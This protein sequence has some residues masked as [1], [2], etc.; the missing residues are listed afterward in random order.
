MVLMLNQLATLYRMRQSPVTESESGTSIN[1]FRSAAS[2]T[3]SSTTGCIITDFLRILIGW[4]F[5]RFFADFVS[6]FTDAPPLL[7]GGH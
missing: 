5:G 4:G 1:F 6:S 2:V 7:L 3:L